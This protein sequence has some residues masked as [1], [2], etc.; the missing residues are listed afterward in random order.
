MLI[1]DRLEGGLLGHSSPREKVKGLT[2]A[3]PF[4]AKTLYLARYVVINHYR[5][6]HHIIVQIYA[7]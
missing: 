2:E 7:S 1:L 6:P 3:H 5:R 4:A